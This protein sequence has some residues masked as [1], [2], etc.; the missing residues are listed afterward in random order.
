MLS[1]PSKAPTKPP[2]VVVND[3]SCLIDLRKVGL[4]R[5]MLRLPYHFTVALPI[6][7]NELL[8]FEPDE[9]RQ[10]E[11]AGLEVVD[12]TSEQVGRA[13]EH[14]ARYATLSAEDCFSLTLAEDPAGPIL[15]TGDAALRRVAEGLSV[16]VHGVLWVVDELHRLSVKAPAELCRC[17]E[18]WRDDPLVRLPK[19][20]LATRIRTLSSL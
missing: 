10:L 18:T 8:D 17:L 4:V 14:R 9:W 16:E 6:R 2:R 1:R 15:L 20:G 3:A 5:A 19:V 13:F 12:L 7:E 11:D